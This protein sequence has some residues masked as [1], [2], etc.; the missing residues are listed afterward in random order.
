MGRLHPPLETVTFKESNT[1]RSH[2]FSVRI[3]RGRNTIRSATQI[4]TLPHYR[5]T[6]MVNNRRPRH[7]AWARRSASVSV[8]QG[9]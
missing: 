8:F 5:R 7:W 4:A 6:R 1:A 9:A 2:G 3:A